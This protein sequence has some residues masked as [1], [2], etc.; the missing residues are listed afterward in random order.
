[1]A[2]QIN[3]Q[4]AFQ[5]VIDAI[6]ALTHFT[7]HP[8]RITIIDGHPYPISAFVEFTTHNGRAFAIPFYAYNYSLDFPETVAEKSVESV[9]Q[10]IQ[11]GLAQSA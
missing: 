7:T 3:A 8:G 2:T 4:E 11:G 10:W 5:R 1:M 6:P 9:I